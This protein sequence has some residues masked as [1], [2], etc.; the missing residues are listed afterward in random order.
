MS[1]SSYFQKSRAT[2]FPAIAGVLRLSTK[3]F[4]DHLRQLCIARLEVD[5]PST[6][7]GWDRREQEATYELGRYVPRDSYPHP[8]LVVNLALELGL[9]A[10]LSSAFYDLSRYGPSKILAGTRTP[11]AVF[12]PS[13]EPSS[14]ETLSESAKVDPSHS[15]VCLSPNNLVRTLQ[16]RERSQLYIHTFLE[17][18]LKD[19]PSPNCLNAGKLTAGLCFESFYFIQL[20][21]LRSVGGIA[22]GRDADPLFTLVQAVDMLERKDFSDGVKQCGLKMC[23]ICKAEF[24]DSVQKARIEVWDLIPGWFGLGDSASKVIE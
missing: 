20:N 12:S 19:R 9:D 7:L 5:W 18:A 4:I 15:P 6:L 3:Y 24:A 13:P 17:A 23:M 22:Y 2:D 8:I 11:P 14:S 16:G 1:P 10:F 21:V